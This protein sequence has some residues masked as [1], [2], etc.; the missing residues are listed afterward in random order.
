MLV[1]SALIC[2]CL[3]TCMSISTAIAQ[4]VPDCLG[5]CAHRPHRDLHRFACHQ[6]GLVTTADNRVIRRLPSNTTR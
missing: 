3:T 5:L 4:I 1:Q 2:S 6:Q